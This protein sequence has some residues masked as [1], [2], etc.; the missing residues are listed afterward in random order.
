MNWRAEAISKLKEYPAR[1]RA[2][3]GLPL[4]I[5]RVDMQCQ[6]AQEAKDKDTTLSALAL[7]RELQERLQ[8]T[9]L[10][11]SFV[12]GALEILD[13]EELKVLDCFYIHPAKAKT[14]ALGMSLQEAYMIREQ[15]LR[16]FTFALYGISE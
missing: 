11:V 9:G 14:E 12:G 6:N 8:E 10:W 1:K 7:K 5:Q 3:E 16:R 13:P 4:E 2:S 15:A